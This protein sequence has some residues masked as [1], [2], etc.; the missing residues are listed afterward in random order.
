ML[1]WRRDPEEANCWRSRKPVRRRCVSSGRWTS[2]RRRLFP[3]LKWTAKAVHFQGRAGESGW[4]SQLRARTVNCKNTGFKYVRHLRKREV[5]VH[6]LDE[7][8][9]EQDGR[10]FT[11]VTIAQIDAEY[12][13]SFRA[14]YYK[15]LSQLLMPER[16]PGVISELPVLHGCN[17]LREYTDDQKIKAVSE[18]LR[19]FTCNGGRFWRGGYFNDSLPF[20]ENRID[21]ISFCVSSAFLRSKATPRN[22]TLWMIAAEIDKEGLRK[23]LKSID[24]QISVYY[25]LGDTTSW[26]NITID[27]QGLV[28]HFFAKKND[29]GCQVG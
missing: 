16:E 21:R 1:W 25:Q 24:Q 19:L 14:S 10:K 4:Q 7:Q 8:E 20:I 26:D 29:L 17:L 15:S 22:D 23:G 5:R 9:G 18:L 11:A 2:R 6:Y 28:G 13:D 12:V 27:F 3:P